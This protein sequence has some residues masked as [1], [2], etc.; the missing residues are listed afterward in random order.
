[1]FARLHPKDKFEGTG[2]G[3]ALCKKIVQRHHGEIQAF[4]EEGKGAT[5]V[6]SLLV[7]QII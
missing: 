5:F 4:G 6:V 2:L 3:L 7:E 1:M